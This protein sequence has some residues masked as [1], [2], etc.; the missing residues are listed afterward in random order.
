MWYS[1]L[2]NATFIIPAGPWTV[3]AP[4]N[5][6]FANL[7]AEKLESLASDASELTALVL[8]HVVN[9]TFYTAGIRSH[10]KIAMASGNVMNAFSRRSKHKIQSI[11]QA[12]PLTVTVMGNL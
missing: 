1:K 7:P 2:N 4:T 5:S 10:Q 11:L 12:F 3:F 9:K 6:A 8:D